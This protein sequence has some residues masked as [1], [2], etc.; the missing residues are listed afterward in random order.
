MIIKGSRTYD[1][2]IFSKIFILHKSMMSRCYNP[3]SSSYDNYGGKGITV[4]KSW[5]NLDDFIKTID[6]VD[7]FDLNKILNGELQLDKDLKQI[8]K[9]SNEKIYSVETC[10]FITPSQ[11]AGLRSNNKDMI[12]IDPNGK[13]Y[14]SRNR[15]SFCREHNIDSRHAFNCLI[16]KNNHYQGWQFFYKENFNEEEIQQPR[17]IEGISPSGDTY[18]FNNVSKFSKEHNLSAPNISMVLS[19][20]NKTHKGWKFVNIQDGFVIQ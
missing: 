6:L 14:E 12:I 13:R 8:G 18:R 7:G 19:G 16:K 17:I 3:N 20:K 15:E 1:N 11:N 10:S 9:H 4:D 2:E 5:H